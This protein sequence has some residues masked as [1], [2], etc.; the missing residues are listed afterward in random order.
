MNNKKVTALVPMKEN[1]ERKNWVRIPK[2]IQ[3]Y[4]IVIANIGFGSKKGQSLPN[5][6]RKHWVWIA[7]RGAELQNSDRNLF[8]ASFSYLSASRHWHLLVLSWNLFLFFLNK[9]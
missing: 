1:S 5:C 3:N 6:E 8:L 4:K 9:A 7:K 2:K